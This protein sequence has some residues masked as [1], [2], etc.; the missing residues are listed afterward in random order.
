MKIH[1]CTVALLLRQSKNVTWYL[2]WYDFVY[3]VLQLSPAAHFVLLASTNFDILIKILNLSFMCRHEIFLSDLLRS[4]TLRTMSAS[5][6]V[7]MAMCLKIWDIQHRLR[8]KNVFIKGSDQ[9][10][11]T[12]RICCIYLQESFSSCQ[13]STQLPQCRRASNRH[14][15]TFP[16]RTPK[17]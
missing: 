17:S 8:T 13:V 3:H 16:V 7:E 1:C 10:I 4:I 15:C 2:G 11:L 12:C 6:S 5:F 14:K 9:Y